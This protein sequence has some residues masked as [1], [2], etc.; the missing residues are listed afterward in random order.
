MAACAALFLAGC[1][2][3]TI[4]TSSD[5][6]MKKSIDTV[7][8]HLDATQRKEFEEALEAI[9]ATGVGNIFSM[10]ADPDSL[11]RKMKDELKGKTAQQVIARGKAI[12]EDRKKEHEKQAAILA[13]RL[14]EMEEASKK[15]R[16]E[17]AAQEI[18]ELEKEVKDLE[19]EIAK[20]A[21]DKAGLA[22]FRVLRSRFYYEES[23][24]RSD[25]TIE[26]TV[27]NNTKYP[28]GRAYFDSTLASPGR[29]IP[30][31]KAAINYEISGGL[32]PGEEVTWHLRPNVFGQ[33]AQAPKDRKDM[34][35]TVVT[36]RIEGADKKPIYD[37]SVDDKITE[38]LQKK[39]ER[40]EELK[41]NL[42]QLTNGAPKQ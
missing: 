15:E 39:Q 1:G 31:V 41:K 30:W 26:L 6:N 38:R 14:R 19:G 2:T 40:M 16:I 35:L 27:R 21:S 9:L 22:Q 8:S 34:V 12:E 24:F 29:T 10:A 17:Q 23:R 11:A 4:D 5:E 18:T 33:W 37:A 13:L 7:K 28:V 25:A 36:T 3:R 42:N 20:A 32:E